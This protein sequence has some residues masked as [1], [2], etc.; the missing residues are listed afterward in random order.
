MWGQST[1]EV[2]R[3]IGL[4]KYQLPIY[5]QYW[6]LVFFEIVPIFLPIFYTWLILLM[7]CLVVTIFYCVDNHFISFFLN[8]EYRMLENGK[9][10][11]R[12]TSSLQDT[13][14]H[15]SHTLHPGHKHLDKQQHTEDRCFNMI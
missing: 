13:K 8:N 12:Y 7:R 1:V 5:F 6:Q 11:Y 10:W 2:Y 9:I 15:L 14:T 3:Y 4:A